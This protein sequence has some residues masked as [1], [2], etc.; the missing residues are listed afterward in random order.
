MKFLALIVVLSATVWFCFSIGR[1]FRLRPPSRRWNVAM[2]IAPNELSAVCHV[3][4][5]YS[6][7]WLQDNSES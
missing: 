3:P 5:Q 6:I 7:S 2:T 4:R 1:Q